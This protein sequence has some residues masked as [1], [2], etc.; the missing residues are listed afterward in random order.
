M[1]E[2]Q[3]ER[4]R[5]SVSVRDSR[6]HSS[7]E[8]IAGGKFPTSITFYLEPPARIAKACNHEV[9]LFGEDLNRAVRLG[10]KPE[11]STVEVDQRWWA[12]HCATWRKDVIDL[13][14]EQFRTFP[15]GKM[16]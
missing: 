4:Y 8:V 9:N 2:N 12:Q 13:A 6:E 5:I 11:P 3:P 1:I 16:G 14:L 10:Q 7:N 15:L